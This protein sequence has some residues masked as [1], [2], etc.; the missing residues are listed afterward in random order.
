VANWR[1]WGPILFGV[2]VLVVFVGLGAVIVS[3]AWFRENLTVETTTEASAVASFDDLR[4][5]HAAKAPL[6]V[7][8]DSG[9]TR[10]PPP[11]GATRTPLNR[12]HVLAWDPRER[13][14]VKFSLPFWF[15]RL[16]ESPIEFGSNVGGLDEVGLQITPGDIERNGPGIVADIELAQGV[17]AIVWA[18]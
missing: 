14:L 13:Q 8:R 7:V 11:E 9:V 17:T 3:V 6:V 12:L 16:K 1:R 2:A 10:H 15:L 18:E 5:Q 4:R